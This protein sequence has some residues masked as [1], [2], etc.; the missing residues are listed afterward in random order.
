MSNLLLKKFS[1][2]ADPGGGDTVNLQAASCEDD[3]VGSASAE[4]RLYHEAHGSRAGEVWEEVDQTFV[5]GHDPVDPV[6]NIGDYQ[7]KW[8]QLSGDT[9]DNTFAAEGVW[10]TDLATVSAS[11]GASVGS[12]EENTGSATVSIRKGTGSILDTAVWEWTVVGSGKG[13]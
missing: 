11:L 12:E 6:T 3:Q 5:Y 13:K 4:I 10:K 9:P 8:D 1:L 2:L 7:I